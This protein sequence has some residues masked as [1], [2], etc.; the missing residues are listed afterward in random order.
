MVISSLLIFPFCLFLLHPSSFSSSSAVVFSFFVCSRCFCPCFPSKTF[1]LFVDWESSLSVLLSL[2]QL[3][4]ESKKQRK[5][6]RSDNWIERRRRET[7]TRRRK[8][9]SRAARREKQEQEE[10]KEKKKV[11][12]R[13][14]RQKQEGEKKERGQCFR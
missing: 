8:R 4:S 2:S 13:S 10:G 12:Y 7:A 14:R 3:F 6:Q 5:Q 9:H 1:P 11:P